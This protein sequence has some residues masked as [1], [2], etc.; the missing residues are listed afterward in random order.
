[1]AYNTAVYEMGTFV[2]NRDLTAAR[3]LCTQLT[4]EI[5][6]TIVPFVAAA[7]DSGDWSVLG[8]LFP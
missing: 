1:M 5:N 7:V 4:P 3:A 6:P 8:R 2:R